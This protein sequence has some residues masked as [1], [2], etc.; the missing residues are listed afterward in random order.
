MDPIDRAGWTG[1]RRI[2]GMKVWQAALLGVLGALDCLVVVAGLAI[3]L[4]AGMPALPAAPPPTATLPPPTAGPTLTPTLTETP[5]TMVFQFPTYTPLGRLA[6]TDT[7]TA[8]PTAAM[9]GW[10]K[11]TVPAVEIWM[12]GTYAAGDPH[13]DAAAIVAALKQMGANFNWSVIEQQL[14][15]SSENYVLWG[16]DSHQGNPAVVTNV[17]VAYDFPNP[18]EPLADYATHFVGAISDSFV[19]IESKNIRHPEYEVQ[20][21][22]LDTKDTQGTPMR[23]AMYAMRDGNII[24]D[25]ICFTAVDEMDARLPSFDQMAVSFRALATA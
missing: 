1:P 18:G 3:V 13:K 5:L 4:G 21:I 24:W 14:K 20:R 10:V 8:A 12:P 9:E 17:A 19:L 22:L 6:E 16:I 15:T 25:M 2:L 11:Y 7:P 23:I